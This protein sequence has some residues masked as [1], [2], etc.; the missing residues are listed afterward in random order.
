MKR[1][2]DQALHATVALW[3]P[4]RRAYRWVWEAAQALANREQRERPEVE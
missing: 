4:L 3:E 1:V 2:V